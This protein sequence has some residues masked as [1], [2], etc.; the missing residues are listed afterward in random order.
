[1]TKKQIKRIGILTAG[2][3]CPGLNAVI[4]AV[5]KSS[6][7]EHN[8]EVIGIRDG[9]AGLVYNNM[10][11][12]NLNDVS[13]ILPQ[14]GTILGTSNRDNPF[15][16]YIE[17][18]GKFKEVDMSEQAIEN[19]HKNKLDALI[20]VGGDGSMCVA[21]KLHEKGMPVV[22]VPKTIDNDLAGT[23][24]T[25]GF[26]TAVATATDAVDKLHTTALAHHR[27]MVIEVM[28]RYAGW[29]ALESGLAG[30]GD[31]ILIPEIPFKIEKVCEKILDRKKKGKNFSLVVVAEGAKPKGGEVVVKKMIANSPE[32]I[33]L[34]GIG[35]FLADAIEKHSKMETR[36]TVLG[37]LQRG[38]DASPFDR[39]LGSRFGCHAVLACTDNDFGKMV[40]LRG[41]GIVRVSISEAIQKP[42]LVDP[43]GDLVRIA[44]MLGTCFGD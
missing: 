38:G 21:N 3:D 27:V 12:L 25:F 36:V 16:M 18:Q 15:G 26:R 42:R 29:I 19:Y 31:V 22:G 7:F 37:H 33:R 28:G 2:G 23:D 13:N 35:N 39:N 10:K 32:K 6:R 43:Q 9:Y 8:I 20:C 30:G 11:L 34:G 4:R 17:S 24:C 5:V 40:A 14:G 41:T 1:M 44:K